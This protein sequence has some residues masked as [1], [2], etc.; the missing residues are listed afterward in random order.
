M[1][2]R[3]LRLARVR[4]H[5]GQAL[6]PEHFAAL[7]G[8]LGAESYLR[9]HV[10]GLPDHGLARLRFQ[11]Q[12]L[13]DG[14]LSVQELTL[15]LP[16]GTLIDVPGNAVVSPLSL[17]GTGATQPLVYLHVLDQVEPAQGQAAY[18]DD[19]RVLQRSLRRLQLST[20]DHQDG[21]IGTFKLAAFEKGST[22]GWHLGEG[23]VPPLLQVGA[24]PFLLE[25]LRALREQLEMLRLQLIAQL[26]DTFLRLERLAVVRDCLASVYQLKS[27]LADMDHGVHRHPYHLFTELRG[28]YFQLCSLHEA[29]PDREVIPYIHDELGACVGALLTALRTRLRLGGVHHNHQKF[30]LQNGL[31]RL[32][33]LPE[34][35]KEA[36]EVYLLI[37]RSNVHDRAPIDDV[38]MSSPTRLDILHRLVL[39]GI[40]FKLLDR[41]HFQHSFGPE[42]D[43][44]QLSR[45]DEWAYACR[46]GGLAFYQTQALQKAS[47]Y[48]FW[49]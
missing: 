14:V 9:A 48:L 37:Q 33:P 31:F 45:G 46:E 20:T 34:D 22:G 12:L 8:S 2:P 18:A 13:L 38:R 19:A 25:Q 15:V 26:Q 17:S 35:A 42:I 32:V 10:S 47:A 24:S 30:T 16:D 28:M 5:L 40:P 43:F 1:T 29:L 41:V 49:R 4:W 6:L 21:A 7:E 44:Y 27:Q 11:E 36:Q 23:F 3:G 39:K